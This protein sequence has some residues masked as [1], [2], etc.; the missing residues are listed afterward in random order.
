[1]VKRRLTLREIFET[2]IAFLASENV[3]FALFDSAPAVNVAARRIPL[4]A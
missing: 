4:A 1:L 2:G 3:L